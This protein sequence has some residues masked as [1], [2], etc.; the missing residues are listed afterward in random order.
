M[1][2]IWQVLLFLFMFV[3]ITMQY[4]L[5]LCKLGFQETAWR[6]AG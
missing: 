4:A 3:D 1:S 6:K 2:I 5:Y